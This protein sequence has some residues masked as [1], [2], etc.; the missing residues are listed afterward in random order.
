M[1][2]NVL[3]DKL[4]GEFQKK[5]KG[6]DFLVNV[7]PESLGEDYDYDKYVH[8][9]PSRAW[10]IKKIA[11]CLKVNK[12]DAILDYGCGKG[13]ALYEFSKFPFKKISGVELSKELSHIAINNME[14]LRLNHIEIF[15]ENALS[16]KKIED[17]N[18]FFFYD[19]FNKDIFKSVVD[20][21][22]ASCDVNPREIRIVYTNP[23]GHGTVLENK[24]FTYLTTRQIPMKSIF[25]KYTPN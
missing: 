17:Y 4:I 13:K 16:F 14:K 3:Y 7:N 10:Q 23:R 24:G 15:N 22:L 9:V 5:T 11:Y 25:Y 21:I 12:N 18:I 20:N 6:V 8:Y 19:P 1:T 2:S